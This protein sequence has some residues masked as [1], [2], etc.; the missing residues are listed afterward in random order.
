MVKWVRPGLLGKGEMRKRRWRI[1]EELHE[2]VKVSPFEP[3][4]GEFKKGGVVQKQGRR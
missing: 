3:G 4:T 2:L 1:R